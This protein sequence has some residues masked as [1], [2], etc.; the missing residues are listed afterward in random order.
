ME[1]AG[2][3]ATCVEVGMEGTDAATCAKVGVE[4]ADAVLE[5][6]VAPWR[7]EAGAAGGLGDAGEDNEIE[8]GDDHVVNAIDLGGGT[9]SCKHLLH[10]P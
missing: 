7:E 6:G 5:D 4:S 1:D 9:H 3:A 2:L 10:L 8:D